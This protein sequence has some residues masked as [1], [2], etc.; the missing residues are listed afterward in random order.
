MTMPIQAAVCRSSNQPLT[1]ETLTLAPPLARQVQ[2]QIVASAICHSDLM[3]MSGAWGDYPPTVY[4]HEAAGVV[5]AVGDE[6]TTPIGSRVLVTLLRACG[7]CA[8][9]ARGAA[10][11][12]AG[13]FATDRQPRLADAHGEPVVAGLKCG[14]FAEAVVVDESQVASIPDDIGL[15]EACLIS[16]GVLTGWGAVFNTA[17]LHDA[18]GTGA[19]V[20]VVGCGGVGIHCVQASVAAGAGLIVGIDTAGTKR[21]LAVQMGAHHTADPACGS[22]PALALTPNRRGF[23][24]VFMAATSAAA[25]EYAASLLAPLGTLVLAGMQA[26]GDCPTLNTTVITSN[27]QRILGSKMGGV[28]LPT[29]LPRLFQFYRDGA[30]RLKELITHRYALRDINTAIVAATNGSSL[31]NIITFD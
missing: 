30:L 4:G 1:I 16:C 28:H 12:C 21:A 10:A 18:A 11:L 15:D 25:V 14:A 31:R 6:V 8:F 29:D 5:T 2:V 13:A 3:F 7:A 27:Q 23:D 20:A 9:C 26:D 24:F 22:A 17:R 19:S